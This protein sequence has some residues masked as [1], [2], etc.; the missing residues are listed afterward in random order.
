MDDS[1]GRYTY[2]GG[3][4]TYPLSCINSTLPIPDPEA[5]E[6]DTPPTAQQDPAPS[7]PPANSTSGSNTRNV[8]PVI[9]F[10]AALALA[11]VGLVA[12]FLSRRSARQRY[13]DWDDEDEI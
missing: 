1:R 7:Q 11:V 3:S 12:L 13:D 5:T 9:F 6:P 4:T 2:L 8:A 10:L